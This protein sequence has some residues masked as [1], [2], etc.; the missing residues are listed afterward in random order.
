MVIAAAILLYCKLIGDAHDAWDFV[1]NKRRTVQRFSPS[2]IRML[3]LI[4]HLTSLPAAVLSQLPANRVLSLHSISFSAIP[5]FA[6]LQSDVRPVIEIF[7][8]ESLKWNS[9]RARSSFA[10]SQSSFE[11]DVGDLEIKGQV[12]LLMFYCRSNMHQEI[13][14]KLMFSLVFHT[15]LAG[16]VVRFGRS[17]LDIN[18]TEDRKI[19]TN[20]R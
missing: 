18:P 4:K 14:K 19:P 20:F 3:D 6:V 1:A 17:E 12:S 5:I 7:Q 11:V 16:S 9:I 15:S 10:V 2:H 13:T 8:G